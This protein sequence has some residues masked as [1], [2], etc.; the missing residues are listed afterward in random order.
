MIVTVVFV[1]GF[2]GCASV[3]SVAEMKEHLDPT[4]IKMMVQFTYICL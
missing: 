1:S 2:W 4:V 3:K